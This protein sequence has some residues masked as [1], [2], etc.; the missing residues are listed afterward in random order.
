LSLETSRA[1]C[2]E[3]IKQLRSDHLRYTNPTP[4]KVSVSAKLYDFIHDL[5]LAEAPVGEL[6]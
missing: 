1:R 2:K 5:W 3:A 4:Y 6:R